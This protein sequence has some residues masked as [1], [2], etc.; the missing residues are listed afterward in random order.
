MLWEDVP[1]TAG[2]PGRAE[3]CDRSTQPSASEWAPRRARL[4]RQPESVRT[5]GVRR[6]CRQ[7]PTWTALLDTVHV[8]RRK[9]PRETGMALM[10]LKYLLFLIFTDRLSQ[11][12]PQASIP[13]HAPFPFIHL[14]MSSAPHSKGRMCPVLLWARGTRQQSTNHCP[15]GADLT[16]S[17]ITLL[18]L[19][20]S[21]T[22]YPPGALT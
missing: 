12:L 15:S 20:T 3:G 5:R 14:F 10:P 18:A 1:P 2:R 19:T 17:A 13:D 6:V 4:L 11:C 21:E 7:E 22:S 8:L 16:R 9:S